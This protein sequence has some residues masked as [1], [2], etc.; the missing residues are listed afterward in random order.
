MSP[1]DMSAIALVGIY[2]CINLPN[3]GH[4]RADRPDPRELARQ[5]RYSNEPD[6]LTR[7]TAVMLILAHPQLLN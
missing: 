1:V 4:C 3:I 6:Y 5:A 2:L 7:T